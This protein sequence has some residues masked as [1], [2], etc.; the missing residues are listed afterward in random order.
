MSRTRP[1]TG[2]GAP[3][4]LLIIVVLSLTTFG[5]LTLA[6]ARVDS[7]L[8]T[9]AADTARAYYTADAA[10]QAKLMEIDETLLSGGN[11][12]GI[13]AL[14]RLD[15]TPDAYCFLCETGDARAIRVVVRI[16]PGAKRAQVL[17]YKLVQLTDWAGQD[18]FHLALPDA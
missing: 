6:S 15:D 8:T 3:S 10:A 14:V 2:V 7:R 17:E 11:P 18:E 5:V 9:R 4:I 13:A 12:S 1:H 16:T